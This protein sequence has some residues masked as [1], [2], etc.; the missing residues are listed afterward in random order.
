MRSRLALSRQQKKF[1]FCL[2]ALIVIIFIASGLYSCTQQTRFA[3]ENSSLHGYH[4]AIDGKEIAGVAEN[5]SSL[6]WSPASDTLFSTINNPPAIIELSKQ[7]ELIRTIPLDF[8]KD[9]ETIEYVD[10]GVFVI[11]DEKDYSIYALSL[12][13]HSEITVLKKLQIALQ[14]TPTNTGFE[15]LAYSHKDRAFYFFKEKKPIAIYKVEGFLEKDDL[16]I[17][18]DKQLRQQLTLKDISGAE[19]N[20]RNNT[21]LILSHESQALEEVT[22]SGE[23]AG[24]MSLEKGAQGLKQDIRQ[25]EGITQDNEGNLYIVGEPNL[26]WKFS[27]TPRPTGQ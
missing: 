16:Q 24:S 15:G 25:A 7:G 11:T 27:K 14:K 10:D 17:S 3:D 9:A 19:F 1:F 12:N 26:F 5:I 18:D 22:L 23:I 4:V 2:L 13:D 21:L 6:T 8:V 20:A